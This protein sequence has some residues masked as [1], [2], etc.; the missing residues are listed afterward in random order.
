[1][2]SSPREQPSVELPGTN[3]L[4]S[5]L[6]ADLATCCPSRTTVSLRSCLMLHSCN[7]RS[8]SLVMPLTAEILSPGETALSTEQLPA[9]CRFHA[10]TAPPGNTFSTTKSQLSFSNSK[11]SSVPSAF[12]RAKLNEAKPGGAPTAVP[13]AIG[14]GREADND[15]AND[16][17]VL[18]CAVA[19]WDEAPSA[20]AKER[21]AGKGAE[22]NG[23]A[24]TSGNLCEELLWLPPC[25]LLCVLML[26]GGLM[27][28][29]K[30]SDDAESC[31]NPKPGSES[32][33]VSGTVVLLLP[34]VLLKPFPLTRKGPAGASI[35]AKAWPSTANL[36][37]KP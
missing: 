30:T 21:G 35:A 1:M 4:A 14:S 32:V 5:A 20:S 9:H 26:P 34:M 23:N 13:G 29:E 2:P 3:S 16:N 28:G 15:S 33:G 17:G 7:I 8:R 37:A 18:G 12:R 10:S 25:G 22:G 36:V 24:G 31:L 27:T 6:N 19:G 11:P